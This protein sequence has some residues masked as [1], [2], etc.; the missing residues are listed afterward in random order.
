M[1]SDTE[2][3]EYKKS[4][5]NVKDMNKVVYFNLMRLGGDYNMKKRDTDKS[6]K[7]SSVVY[8]E[9]EFMNIWTFFDK[10]VLE[11]KYTDKSFYDMILIMDLTFKKLYKE[12]K[13]ICVNEYIFNNQ[14]DLMVSYGLDKYMNYK[15]LID[16]IFEKCMTYMDCETTFDDIII[17]YDM[18]KEF[19]NDKLLNH[20]LTEFKNKNR[21]NGLYSEMTEKKF[22]GN[23]EF[24]IMKL[25]KMVDFCGNNFE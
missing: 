24:Y 20:I 17:W 11:K 13:L 4:F 10:F 21:I 14:K 2:L 1:I 22:S 15:D 9:R 23:K 19:V 8:T 5:V 16:F 6:V 25:G 12:N 7:W 18:K 3:S